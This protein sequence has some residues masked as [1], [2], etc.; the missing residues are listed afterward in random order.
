M[1]Q[2]L[3]RVLRFLPL[4]VVRRFLWYP[5]TTHTIC[6]FVLCVWKNR[7]SSATLDWSDSS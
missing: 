4:P 5:C 7:V 1:P 6:G 2:K 3:V